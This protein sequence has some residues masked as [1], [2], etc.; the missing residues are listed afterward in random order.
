MTQL[1]YVIDGG[2]N[3]S[4][5]L[6]N[7]HLG[8]EG[9]SVQIT[10]NHVDTSNNIWHINPESQDGTDIEIDLS[11]EWGFHSHV[12]STISLTM[13]GFTPNRTREDGAFL[14]LFGVNNTQYFSIFIGLQQGQA[15][16]SYP[17]YNQQSL[18]Q[19]ENIYLDIIALDTPERYH[20]VSN[21][22]YITDI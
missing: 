14:I 10:T 3:R 1:T 5:T 2:L 6:N 11:N 4:V 8:S 16:K 21:S 18:A 22:N 17:G 20:R 13:N 9:I 19:I 12:Q 15:W 7:T